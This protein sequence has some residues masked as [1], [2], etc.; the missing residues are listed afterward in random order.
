MTLLVLKPGNRGEVSCHLYSSTALPPGKEPL[1]LIRQEARWPCSCS[2]HFEE[3][4]NF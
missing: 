3:K 1:L 4:I 2:G